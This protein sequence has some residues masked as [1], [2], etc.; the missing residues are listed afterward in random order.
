[1]GLQSLYGMTCV[2]EGIVMHMQGYEGLD[3]QA[4]YSFT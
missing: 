4:G 2:D 1:M 3:F